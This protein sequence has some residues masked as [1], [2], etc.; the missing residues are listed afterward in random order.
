MRRVLDFL[1]ETSTGDGGGI[2]DHLLDQKHEREP[3]FPELPQ[4]P[5]PVLVD[6]DVPSPVHGVV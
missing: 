5:E 2:V 3:T 6:P 4:D 1:G